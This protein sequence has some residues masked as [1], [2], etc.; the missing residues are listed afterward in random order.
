MKS[1]NLSQQFFHDYV[2]PVM[3]DE[4]DFLL[5]AI[6]VGLIGD[7]SEVLGFDDA[8]SQDHNFCPRVVILIA[9]E[10]FDQVGKRLEQKLLDSAPTEYQGH[11]L[12]FGEFRKWVEVAPLQGFFQQQLGIKTTPN[13]YQDWLNLDEQ[14]LLEMTA[15][16]IFFDPCGRLNAMVKKLAF[17]PD[18]VRYYLL[19]QGFVRLSEVSAIERAILRS[20][21]IG[22]ELYRAWFIYFVIKILHLQN[23]R[24]CPYRKWMGRS[25]EQ[26]SESGRI[27]KTKI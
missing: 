16:P 27:L 1:I 24:Y 21:F 22:I 15:G 6:S 20:D 3:A 7:G 26:L 19:H 14:K 23:R 12:L 5:P 13:T 25:L 4:F 10:Q 9:D 8:I 17:Y 11:K 2:F 18:A